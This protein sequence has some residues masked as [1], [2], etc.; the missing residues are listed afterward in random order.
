MSAYFWFYMHHKFL[1]ISSILTYLTWKDT[2][3]ENAIIS[4][5]Q[6]PQVIIFALTVCS[7]MYT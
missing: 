4:K 6:E 7:L 3:F 5:F 1:M 2:C